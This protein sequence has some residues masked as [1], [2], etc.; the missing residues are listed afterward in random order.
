MKVKKIIYLTSLFAL[1]L[2]S[3]AIA[4]CPVCI[5]TIAGGL[6]LAK[7]LGVDDT[8]S[9]V[10]I[11]GLVLAS[12]IWFGNWL[13]KKKFRFRFSKAV[14]VI[15]FYAVTI[16]SLYWMKFIGYECTKIW[17]IDKLLV[18]MA[19]GSIALYV[20]VVLSDMLKKRRG[21]KVYFKFQKV[22]IP[23]LFLL[24]PSIIFYLITRC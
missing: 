7:W 21:E 2:C 10:W 16:L 8:I 4:I 9:G 3:R 23:I 12:A 1:L 6:E 24:I 11:G 20:G 17:G 15:L 22:V 14:I 18:G 5:V 19:A 13:G